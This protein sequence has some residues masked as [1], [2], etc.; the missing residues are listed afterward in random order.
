M[1][2]IIMS[3]NV[4]C[5]DKRRGRIAERQIHFLLTGAFLNHWGSYAHTKHYPP[6]MIGC[7]KI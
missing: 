3:K 7:P 5:L 6:A 2:L 4:Y 1:L